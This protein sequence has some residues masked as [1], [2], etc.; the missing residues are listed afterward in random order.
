MSQFSSSISRSFKIFFFVFNFTF[1]SSAT[2]SSSKT[3]KYIN[4]GGFGEYSVEYAADYRTL[5]IST[6]PF[7]LCFYNTTPNAYTLAIRM[8]HRWS[9][10]LMRWVWDA[11]R[12]KPV[13]ENA[14]LSFQRDGNLILADFDGT[15]AWQTGTANQG[16]VGLDL[17][18]NGNLVL[19]D[20]RGKFIWQSFDHPADTLLVGQNLRSNGPNRLVSRASTMDGSLGA[21]SFVM[22]QRYWALYYKVKNSQKPLLYYKSDEF[23]DGRGSLANLNFYCQPQ[24]EQAYAFEVGFTYDMNSSPS[25]GTY[26]LTRPK[27]NST[28][29]M[30][31]LESDDSNREISECKLPQRCGSLGVCEDNQCVAC[32]RPQGLLGW[33]KSCAPPALPPCKRGVKL[34]YYKVVGVEHFLNG[35]SEGEGPMKLVDCRNKC[36]NDCG[37]L[38]FFYKEESSKCLLAPVLGTLVEV[39]SPSHVGYIKMSK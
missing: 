23:G 16:V 20:K 37:C 8:G 24:N 33:S 26:I 27:Y 10:S 11:N 29:S 7:Q 14:T 15:I 13:H 25:S 9:E 28:Y 18:P 32:P 19:Y 21:Y 17:L 36:S 22:E 34:D 39:S 35:Y 5:P 31:R 30:L 2:V 3:F 12:G 38:G 6:S 4:Q 1:L